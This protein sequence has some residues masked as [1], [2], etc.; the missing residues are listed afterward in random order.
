MAQY[1]YR[2]LAD[3]ALWKFGNLKV[4]QNYDNAI[5][6]IRFIPKIVSSFAEVII[7]LL[8]SKLLIVNKFTPTSESK[9]SSV[10]FNNIPFGQVFSDHFF[11]CDFKDGEWQTGEIKKLEPMSIHPG[12]LAW[13]YGQAIFEGMKAFKD[14]DNNPVL[15]RPELHAQRF[16]ASARRLCMPEFPEQRFL[17]SLQQLVDIER[18]WIPPSKGSAL[19]LRPLMIAMDEA[20]GVRPSANYRMMILCL[21]VGPYYTKPVK[22]IT[23]QEF[24]RA[25]HGGVGEAKAAGNYA[26]SLQPAQL[27]KAN[28]FDQVMWLDAKEF[29]YVQEVGTMNI[30]FVVDGKII[31][32]ITNGTI[33]KGITRMSAIE[34]LK[35]AGYEVEEKLVDINDLVQ[36][37]KEGKFTEAF[38]TGTAAVSTKIAAIQHDGF[39]MNLTEKG[40]PVATEVK[41]TLDGIRYGDV[42]DKWGWIVPVKSSLEMS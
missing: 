35:S 28:G 27:A 32:P 39:L 13:H 7:L 25:A 3:L 19:Y 2:C 23:E 17:E 16:N 14:Q 24:I 40:H 41:D 29:K 9:L 38:G 30:F 8:V 33:L 36:A 18:E 10:D 12:N 20:I 42:E 37:Y 4:L 31:T 34:Y 6:K 26:G 1:Y 11:I 22:L 5:F 21:P 15:F